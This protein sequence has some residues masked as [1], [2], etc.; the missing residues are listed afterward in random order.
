MYDG[1]NYAWKWTEAWAK[2]GGL[3][4]ACHRVGVA[5]PRMRAARARRPAFYLGCQIF[6]YKSQVSI[7]LHMYVNNQKIVT[8]G[9]NM[10]FRPNN[11]I[12]SWLSAATETWHCAFLSSALAPRISPYLSLSCKKASLGI[13]SKHVIILKLYFQLF[14]IKAKMSY[15]LQVPVLAS[16]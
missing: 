11:S 15:V 6:W 7:K 10:D 12:R 3:A 9:Q 4:A 16:T 2:A 13:H 1:T 8:G 5:R 14:H